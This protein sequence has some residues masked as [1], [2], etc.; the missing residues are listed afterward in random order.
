M[1][2][3]YTKKSSSGS[4]LEFEGSNFLRSRLVMA[5][6]SGKSVKIRAIRSRDQNPGLREFE[7]SFVRLMD[8]MTNGSRIEVS[9][10]G[11]TL[12]YQ[13]G[14]LIGG[15][16]EHDCNPDRGIGY[17][18]EPLMYLG[19]FCK[20]PLNVTLKGVT[21][22]QTDPSPDLLRGSN[23][24]VLKS[25]FLIDEGLELKVQKRG[26]APEG[27]GQ[28]VFKCPLRRGLK[29][30]Q[31]LEQGKIKRIRGTA[32]A[33]R[34]SPA[35]SNRMVESAKGLLLK[36]I[37]DV[38][39]YTDN[40]KGAASGKSAGFGLILTAETT[41]GATLS[42]EVTSNPKG[43]AIT[44]PEDLGLEC[45]QRSWRRYSAAAA[46]TPRPSLSRSS[47]WP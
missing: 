38:Y 44:V 27:G 47:T 10:T 2:T 3:T 36:F 16:L 9:E 28:V 41:T 12:F 35:M 43:A 15:K 21:N 11:T 29:A 7:A 25:Y 18:L 1:T 33:A 22:N 37:P 5:T 6:L 24:P 46:S 31:L 19:P 17:Y 34:V 20:H 14:L 39:I 13:P 45:A 8:K 23:M 32:W 26:A 40:Y 4:L 30:M 42:A